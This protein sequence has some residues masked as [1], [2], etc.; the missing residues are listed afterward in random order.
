M[1][2]LAKKILQ[3]AHGLVDGAGRIMNVYI[4]ELNYHV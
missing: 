4:T 3:F 2:F 1:G